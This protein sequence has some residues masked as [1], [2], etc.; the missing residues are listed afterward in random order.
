MIAEQS[1]SKLTAKL[2]EL[3]DEGGNG[4]DKASGVGPGPEEKKELKAVRAVVDAVR[5][6]GYINS[7]E[8]DRDKNGKL[9][10][11]YN[12]GLLV[13]VQTFS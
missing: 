5:L 4:E 11:L 8:I 9:D 1:N 6:T 12:G 7:S 2:A 13:V 3:F 10:C